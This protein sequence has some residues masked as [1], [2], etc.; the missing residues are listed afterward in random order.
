MSFTWTY[1]KLKNVEDCPRRHYELDIAR[2]YKDGE[3]EELVWGNYVHAELAKACSTGN[4]LPAELEPYQKWVDRV[5]RWNKGKLYVEQKYAI[6][7]TFEKSNWKAPAVWMRAIADV[8]Y[9]EPPVAVTLDWKTGKILDNPVQLGLVAQ[10]VFAMFPDVQIVASEYVWLKEDTTS[11][12]NFKREDMKYLWS[13]LLPRVNDYEQRI[14][15]QRFEPKPGGL[16][17]RYCPVTS[18]PHHG[19]G[20]R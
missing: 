9:V 3:S 17:K 18:C 12:E 11:G 13:K 20:S 14:A 4:K 7:K 16:C 10:C 5:R 15:T 6:T 8:V 2:N 19:K 1:S